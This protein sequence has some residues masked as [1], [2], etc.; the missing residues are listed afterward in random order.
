MAEK[1]YPGA[2]VRNAAGVKMPC[3]AIAVGFFKVSSLIGR[4]NFI[5]IRV[6]SNFA[7]DPA[8]L[9]GLAFIAART[10]EA[11]NG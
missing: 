4:S 5:A 8:L 3:H 11:G 6:T 9:A 7:H 1:Q 10:L 2:I